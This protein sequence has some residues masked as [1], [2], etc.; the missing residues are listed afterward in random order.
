MHRAGV[1]DALPG[2]DPN[3]SEQEVVV[4]GGG[5]AEGERIG[6]ST[7]ESGIMVAARNKEEEEEEEE[8]RKRSAATSHIL[9][10]DIYELIDG[11]MARQPVVFTC[12][13]RE[14]LCVDVER[15]QLRHLDTSAVNEHDAGGGAGLGKWAST[16]HPCNSS[17]SLSKLQRL[18]IC[19]VTASNR[20]L[21]SCRQSA[22]RMREC[23]MEPSFTGTGFT[24]ILPTAQFTECTRPRLLTD[25][26]P[27]PPDGPWQ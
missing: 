25:N 19:E 12:S 8:E 16:P 9:P 17:I 3:L 18:K 13:S 21:W 22:R 4:G 6:G 2:N 26:Q 24:G 7:A 5:G 14:T 15:R 10:R 1:P 11:T 20:H 23:I 27:S